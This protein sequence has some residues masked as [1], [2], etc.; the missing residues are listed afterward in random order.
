MRSWRVTC[1]AVLLAS[2]IAADPSK[3]CYTVVVGKEASQDGSVLVGHNEVWGRGV[4]DFLSVPRQTH[5]PGSVV[6]LLNGRTIPQV[7]RTWRYLWS[8]NPGKSVADSYMNEWGVSIIGNVTSCSPELACLPEQKGGMRYMLRPLIAQRARTA[9]EGVEVLSRL[10]K[11][12]GFVGGWTYVIA[13]SREAWM[14]SLGKGNTWAANRVP[15]DEVVLLP[16]VYIATWVD[17]NDTSR[18]LTSPRLIEQAVKAGWF[19]P[20]AGRPFSFREVYG[21]GKPGAIDARQQRGY[22]LLTGK[23]P[24][25]ADGQQLPFSVRPAQKLGVADVMEILRDRGAGG[26]CSDGTLEGSV[27]QL[28]PNMPPSIG[29]VYW[30]ASRVP[31]KSMFVPWY[32]GVTSVDSTYSRPIGLEKHLTLETRL[33]PTKEVYEP[34]PRFCWWTFVAL[35]RAM[36]K[37]TTRKAQAARGLMRRFEQL[38]LLGQKETDER[39]L[40]LHDQNPAAVGELLTRYSNEMGLKAV[41]LG[42]VLARDLSITTK[43][44]MTSR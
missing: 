12:H 26:I 15:D 18:C 44:E 1:T 10:V 42:E 34:D 28:R 16:N 22:Y 27:F 14:V 41:R 19:D 40:E 20:A 23:M 24:A 9:R 31:D 21:T 7:E 30:R 36:D 39:A 3:A 35:D 25:L 4:I 17:P 5:K 37:A 2:G 11:E 38:L 6:R 33:H 29:C 13:D 43:R 8:C 32:C